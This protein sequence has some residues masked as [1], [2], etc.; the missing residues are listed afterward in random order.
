MLMIR[1][2]ILIFGTFDCFH[3]GHEFVLKEAIKRGSVTVIIARDTNVVRIKGRSPKESEG[4]RMEVIRT[5][6]PSCKVQLGSEDDFLEPVRLIKPSLI[7]LG[8]DQKLPPH[9]HEEDL[10]CKVERLPPYHPEKYKSS[11]QKK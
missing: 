10:H 5:K 8:Y 11:L 3:P 9:V 1:P 7:L 6:F 4:I 2:S